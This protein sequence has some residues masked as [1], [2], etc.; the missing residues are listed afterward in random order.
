MCWFLE[1][2]D[3]TEII[4][5][6]SLDVGPF[7]CIGYVF[8]CCLWL[9]CCFWLILSYRVVGNGWRRVFAWLVV[10]S[11]VTVWCGDTVSDTDRLSTDQMGWWSIFWSIARYQR[12]VIASFFWPCGHSIYLTL[13]LPIYLL[14]VHCSIVFFNLF[15]HYAAWPWYQGYDASRK[16]K[17][18]LLTQEFAAKS[19]DCKG[20]G[21]WN[22]KDEGGGEEWGGCPWFSSIVGIYGCHERELSWGWA[23]ANGVEWRT[24][25]RSW[26]S[27]RYRNQVKT[28]SFFSVLD[29]AI[30]QP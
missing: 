25:F 26:S 7:C 14:P 8:S 17:D 21:V 24:I 5:F 29:F 10:S 20:D 11:V 15:T 1:A 19:F 23:D 6:D 16:G 12:F 30:L 22:W 27:Y 18:F 2:L 9:H 13:Y 3:R 4:L 28:F